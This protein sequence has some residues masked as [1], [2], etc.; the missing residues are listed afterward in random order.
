MDERVNESHLEKVKLKFYHK[1]FRNFIILVF[2]F[3]YKG[4]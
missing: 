3:F 4:F 1:K 2:F